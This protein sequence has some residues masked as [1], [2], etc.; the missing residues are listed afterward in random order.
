MNIPH[1]QILILI[2]SPI[3]MAELR[4]GAGRYKKS[5]ENLLMPDVKEV[6]SVTD[7]ES[8]ISQGHRSQLV[9]APLAKSGAS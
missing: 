1:T 6:L 2:P 5:L 4:S 9:R 8:H 3:I 7:R